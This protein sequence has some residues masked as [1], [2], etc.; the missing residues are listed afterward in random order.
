MKSCDILL[1]LSSEYLKVWRLKDSVCVNYDESWVLEGGVLKGVF[2]KGADFEEACDNYL[3]QIRG[4]QLV[5]E[6]H[7]HKIKKEVYVLG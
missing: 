7:W 1:S 4:K 2:G 5:F 6:G 3:S